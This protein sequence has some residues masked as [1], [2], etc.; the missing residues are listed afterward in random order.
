MPRLLTSYI[1]KEMAGPFCICLFVLTGTALLSKSNKLIEMGI[2]Y[3]AGFGSL[4]L[5]VLSIIPSFLIYI[6]PISFLVAVLFAFNR[7]SSDSELA[8][9]KASG[10][11]L[12]RLALP[13]MV[14]ALLAALSTLAVTA[15]LFPLGNNQL[16]KIVGAVARTKSVAVIQENT[17]NTAFN[18]LT[19]YTGNIPR[20]ENTL[21]DVF[22]SDKREAGEPTMIFAKRGSFIADP[23]GK[24]LTLKLAD[25]T[26]HSS[27]E[28]SGEYRLIS[29][30]TYDFVV[31]LQGMPVARSA[32]TKSNKELYVGELLTR[33]EKRGAAGMS[34]APYIIDLHKRFALPASVFVF[35]LLAVPLGVQKIRSARFTSFS[36]ALG[37]VL[38][39]Y[40]LS[41]A[42]ESLGDEGKIGPLVS[43]WGSNIVM[44]IVGCYV[45]YRVSRDMPIMPFRRPDRAPLIAGHLK[46]WS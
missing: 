2:T 18:G 28:V 41:T 16:H 30:N 26:V 29:F 45:Y 7:L 22:I 35:A 46:R 5:F 13:V 39:Y 8:A 3:R 20:G 31:P 32:A 19:L 14:L 1:F 23:D 4:G 9:M 24:A 11:S 36:V 15:Y 38:I 27:N 21:L 42:M 37:V 10:I 25:G 43:V 34:A 40:V 44:G 12:Y 17:F 6:I 33:I